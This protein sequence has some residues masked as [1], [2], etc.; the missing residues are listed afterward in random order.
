MKVIHFKKK[1]LICF[2]VLVCVAASVFLNLAGYFLDCKYI[3]VVAAIHQSNDYQVRSQLLMEAMGQ[4]GACDS[5]QAAEIW[6]SGLKKRSAA[7]QYSVM[8]AR[9]QGDY[10]KQLETEAPNWVTGVSSPWVESYQIVKTE[11]PDEDS[12]IV[13]LVF[14]TATSTGPAESYQ[15]TL[16]IERQGC[17]WRIIKIDAEDGLFPYTRFDPQSAG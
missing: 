7:L 10:A 14:F 2:A 1:R 16:R 5:T 15:A 17:F 6:A 13:E 3:G 8:D 12:S 9:L 11:S 4:I